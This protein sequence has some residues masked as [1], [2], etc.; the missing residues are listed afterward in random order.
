MT[1][2]QPERKRLPFHPELIV[3]DFDG[4]FTDNRV[5]VDENGIESV[6]CNRSDGLAIDFLR[7]KIPMIILSTE[8]NKVVA[9]RAE[10]LRIEVWQ[11]VS[12]K[13]EAVMELCD[14]RHIQPA[15]VVFIGNDI[16]DLGAMKVCGYSVVPADAHPKVL[17]EVDHVLE[18]RGG[19]G[20]IREFCEVFMGM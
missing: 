19:D 3:F 18:K 5:Y 4:V 16:N 1:K 13:K 8:T 15:K 6:V 2:K 20:V 17:A 11:S 12:D 14:R 9:R 7:S 10:K